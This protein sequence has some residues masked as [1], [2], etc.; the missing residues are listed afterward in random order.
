MD[1]QH[2]GS[3]IR[4]HKYINYKFLFVFNKKNYVG[5]KLGDHFV[6]TIFRFSKILLY[7]CVE[8][9]LWFL[10]TSDNIFQIKILLLICI[11]FRVKII[12]TRDV[13]K[14]IKQVHIYITC[15]ISSKITI[16]W[17]KSTY[18]FHRC[19]WV[20]WLEWSKYMQKCQWIFSELKCFLF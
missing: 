6:F 11:Y 18:I 1:L 7:A 12:E 20:T 2:V 8:E 9:Q 3:Y 5:Q 13:C 15:W 17:K 4:C 19:C 10:W 16:L 14:M